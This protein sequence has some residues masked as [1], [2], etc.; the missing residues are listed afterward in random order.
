MKYAALIL[1]TLIFFYCAFGIAAQTVDD[2]FFDGDADLDELVGQAT[3]TSASGVSNAQPRPGGGAI[4]ESADAI[5]TASGAT[6]EHIHGAELDASGR[7]VSASSFNFEGGLF[8]DVDGFEPLAGGGFA[9]ER[10]GRILH[11]GS[12]LTNAVGVRFSD[13]VLVAE[14]VGSFSRGHVVVAELGGLAAGESAFT[15]DRAESLFA[16]CVLASNVSAAKVTTYSDGI[17]LAPETDEPIAV[18]DCAFNDVTFSGAGGELRV[19]GTVP[20]TYNVI[21]GTLAVKAADH[22]EQIDANASAV[23]ELDPQEGIACATITPPG[24][25]WFNARDLRQDFGVHVPA[26]GTLFKL[27]IRKAAR[28]HYAEYDGLADLVEQRVWLSKTVQFLKYP[29]RGDQPDSL[30]MN[31]LYSNTPGFNATL[32]LN[33]SSGLIDAVAI[34]GAAVAGEAATMPN[35]YYHLREGNVDGST[36][37]LLRIDFRTSLAALTQSRVVRYLTSYFRPEIA[38]DDEVLVQQNNESTIS[39]LPPGHTNINAIVD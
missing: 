21:N 37:R 1:S 23:V 34:T 4:V 26:N 25:Y 39:V 31:A 19:A 16:G 27:C 22:R 10:A 20:A 24:T 11:L 30:L 32:A 12:V 17:A 2:E 14:S 36:H 5:T 13:N 18:R 9:I 35:S 38:M 15:V 7:L 33:R 29:F 6:F 8:N 28:Q 3:G